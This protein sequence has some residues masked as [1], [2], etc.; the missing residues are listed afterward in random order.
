MDGETGEEENWFPA[1]D[2]RQN[3][4][5]ILWR[6]VFP[7]AFGDTG[8]SFHLFS[9]SISQQ[10]KMCHVCLGTMKTV[11]IL[12]RTCLS[13]S[14]G[15]SICLYVLETSSDLQEVVYTLDERLLLICICVQT[16]NLS[17]R[18]VYFTLSLHRFLRI[19]HISVKDLHLY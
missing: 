6:S 7:F 3:L 11:F 8:L 1:Q 10:R 12:L 15:A 18:L 19:C 5:R 4:C 13:T 2:G 14:A 17:I 16:Q 9:C